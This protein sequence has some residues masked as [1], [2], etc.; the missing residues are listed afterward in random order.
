VA[1][2][3]VLYSKGLFTV[4][5]LL[6]TQAFGTMSSSWDNLIGLIWLFAGTS[7]VNDVNNQ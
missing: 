3:Q 2:M 6:K 7:P 1:V 4:S 5:V